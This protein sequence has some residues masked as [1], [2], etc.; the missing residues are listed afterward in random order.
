MTVTHL[1]LS[2]VESLV[3]VALWLLGLAT[4]STLLRRRR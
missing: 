1:Q 4:L 2:T 3:I